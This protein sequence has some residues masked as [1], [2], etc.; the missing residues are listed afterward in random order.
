L[1]LASPKYFLASL[2]A[3]LVL[4][5]TTSA[6]RSSRFLLKTIARGI[7]NNG[8]NKAVQK[9]FDLKKSVD[10]IAEKLVFVFI[11]ANCSLAKI[12]GFLLLPEDSLLSAVALLTGPFSTSIIISSDVAVL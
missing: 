12:I 7:S 6:C 10:F 8:D 4:F 3:F 11:K 2:S 9:P 5:P 1:R